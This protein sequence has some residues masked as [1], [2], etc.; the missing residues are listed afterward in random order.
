MS[1][2][3]TRA[4]ALRLLEL[5]PSAPRPAI[6]RAYRRLARQH[7][8]DVGGDPATFH[9]L[10]AAMELLLDIG[11]DGP[12]PRVVRGRP[13]RAPSDWDAGNVV[14][15]E[16]VDLDAVDWGAAPPGPGSRLTHQ[17][18]ALHLA[19]GDE[20]L[21]RGLRATSRAPG[22]RLN[23]VADSLSS[24]LTAQLTVRPDRDDRGRD[25]VLVEVAGAHRRARRA[26]DR[27]ALHGDWLRVRGS[28]TT[29]LRSQLVPSAERR[30]TAL[31]TA[32]RTASLLERLA[33][34]LDAWTVTA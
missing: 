13:S 16:P 5:P 14:D 9:R 10:H 11:T 21:V 29:R 1:P 12:T 20:P 18:L 8:P 31:R 26:L 24:D 15:P 6:K 30:A 4:Q 7:H 22:S 33:W 34:P 17:L 3:L 32:D 23:R 27:V 19:Q 25:V 2:Q 28:S